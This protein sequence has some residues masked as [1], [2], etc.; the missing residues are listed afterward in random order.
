VLAA[1]GVKRAAFDAALLK[2]SHGGT[3]DAG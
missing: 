3:K 2:A 1:V